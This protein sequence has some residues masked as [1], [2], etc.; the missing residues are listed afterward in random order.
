MHPDAVVRLD[1]PPDAQGFR[2]Q[3]KILETLIPKV[4]ETVEKW[5]ADGVIERVPSNTDNRWN[6]PL[7]LAPKKDS[8]GK[9]TDKRPCLDPRHINKYLKADR[10]PLPNINDIFKKFANAEVYTT[11]DLTNA[12]HRF[13]I[14]PEH[15]HK[16]AFTDPD[17]RQFMFVGCPFGLT[18]ISSKFQR[19]MTTLFTQPPFQSFVATFVDDIVIYSRRY[20]EHVKHTQLVIDELTR[21][22]C[23]EQR[24]ILPRSA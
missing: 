18:P 1:T 15:R 22:L 12:F 20:E 23:F 9:Y 8:T 11:L 17:G 21:F 10:F 2:I 24:E 19:V 13:P 5:L 3:Y 7:T 4:R 14:L 6:S 16:T